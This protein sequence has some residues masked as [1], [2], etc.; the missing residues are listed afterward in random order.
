ML[1]LALVQ[2]AAAQVKV[3]TEA[4]LRSNVNS[5]NNVT[6]DANITLGSTLNIPSKKTVHIDLNGHA[7]KRNLREN[8]G[9]K[10]HVIEVMKDATLFIEDSQDG[11]MIAGG[12]ADLGGAIYNGGTLHVN[13]GRF[14][15]NRAT[16]GGAI[17]NKDMGTTVHNLVI[18]GGTFTGN[19][20]MSGNGGAVYNAG[21]MRMA[22]GRMEGNTSAMT[23]GAIYNEGYLVMDGTPYVNGNTGGNL[24]LRT[25]HKL[26]FTWHPLEEGAQ[27]AIEYEEGMSEPFTENFRTV[28]TGDPLDYFVLPD[29][30]NC[31]FQFVNMSTGQEVA[32]DIES[33]SYLDRTHSSL[34]NP[35][36]VTVS[37]ERKNKGYRE[38]REFPANETDLHV[39]NGWYAVNRSLV[40]DQ[41]ITISQ[42]TNIIL[43]D[44]AT[45]F[46]NNG[47][48]LTN[49]N[50]T[51]TIYAQSDG[52]N[53]GGLQ[54]LTNKTVAGQFSAI[55][56]LK[57]TTGGQFIIKGGRI[58]TIGNR[59]CISGIS[60][61]LDKFEMY[62]GEL[63]AEGGSLAPGIASEQ[64]NGGSKLYFYGGKVT[65][66]SANSVAIGTSD[67]SCS[68]FIRIYGGDI[69]ALGGG[70]GAGM[71][72]AT[73]CY[74]GYDIEINGGTV[75]AKG[76]RGS[77]GIGMGISTSITHNHNYLSN[78]GV[79]TITGGKVT[80]IGGPCDTDYNNCHGAGIGGGGETTMG[81]VNILGG[82]VLAIGGT[83]KDGSRHFAIGHGHEKPSKLPVNSAIDK[84]TFGKYVSVQLGGSESSPY[85]LKDNRL[86]QPNN[87]KELYITD[88]PHDIQYLLSPFT[89]MQHY[90]Q[91]LHCDYYMNPEDHQIQALSGRCEVCGYGQDFDVRT[92]ALFQARTEDGYE[93][94]DNNCSKGTT[95][96][97]PEC[98]RVPEGYVFKGWLMANNVPEGIVAGDDEILMMPGERYSILE[99][100]QFFAR[101]QRLTI[102]LHDDDEDIE[103]SNWQ[104]LNEHDGKK[105]YE[106]TISGRTLHRDGKWQ[107]LCLP[108]SLDSFEGTLLE[109]ATLRQLT[110]A[111]LTEG[112]LTLTF[113]EAESLKA[114]VPYL[115][116]WESGGDVIDPVFEGV[117]INNTINPVDNDILTFMG[118]YSTMQL[119]S[120][121]TSVL[122]LGSDNKLH[123]PTTDLDINAFRSFF[124]MKVEDYIENIVMEGL[125]EATGISNVRMQTEKADLWFTVDGRRLSGKPQQKGI[126]IH[127]GRK[128]TL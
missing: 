24:Y 28:N 110:N 121:D 34:D 80:A 87:A 113:G 119:E 8:A 20:S 30:M 44:G 93:G 16:A 14:E 99:N 68:A 54:A 36:H 124:G 7:L 112:K 86:K 55:G 73:S 102:T 120:G 10:G 92:F 116:K 122:Y 17:Y 35:N 4:A 95:L 77:A 12:Y 103:T 47:F 123:Y 114:G 72:T 74:A 70:Q 84:V 115:V 48:L 42:N 50:V 101:Y 38:V 83:K 58:S 52:D 64:P 29:N 81:T 40:L 51:L 117:T 5:G 66:S 31:R 15:N 60:G 100:T 67:P 61:H 75:Y 104:L 108:F 126:Y 53:M 33:Y 21:S 62:A 111:V 23:G 97:L 79:V 69:T 118:C 1:L 46:A 32:Y 11:G 76:G 19:L 107:T 57:E 105:A 78:P 96:T 65:A 89:H 88:C 71:G 9:A 43:C 22:G 6:L 128:V 39:S 82:T 18:R 37:T 3:S 13:G 109:G 127:N 98:E 2:T 26:T 85:V 59:V 49:D 91:C 90:G 125:D 25:G 27:I 106:V 45:L 56:Q 41:T 94:V 63:T